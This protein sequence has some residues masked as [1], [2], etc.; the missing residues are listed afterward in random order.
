MSLRNTV[1][2]PI[3]PIMPQLES[4]AVADNVASDAF[5]MNE[6]NDIWVQYGLD[7]RV[8]TRRRMI[9]LCRVGIFLDYKIAYTKDSE[10]T[11]LLGWFSRADAMHTSFSLDAIKI[12]ATKRMVDEYDY[13]LDGITEMGESQAMVM[14][15]TS[16]IC[17]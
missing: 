12:Y 3:E 6:A 14:M 5:N 2:G 16:T 15:F 17:C 13:R 7:P 8:N 11:A 4:W 10:C 9:W 1:R